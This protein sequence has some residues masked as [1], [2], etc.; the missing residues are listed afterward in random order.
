[1]GRRVN[2]EGVGGEEG[3]GEEKRKRVEGNERKVEV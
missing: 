1:M 3:E 2:E